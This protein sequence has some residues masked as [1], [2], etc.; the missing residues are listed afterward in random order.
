MTKEEKAVAIA[1]A[2]ERLRA[3]RDLTMRSI[4]DVPWVTRELQKEHRE[5]MEYLSRLD[6]ALDEHTAY[7]ETLSRSAPHRSAHS[8]R[9]A[10][11]HA[12]KSRA[13]KARD[14]K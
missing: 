6:L 1:I 3:A 11:A 4:S 9:A 10:R 7:I 13:E 14:G 12:L 2:K 8:F 5:A